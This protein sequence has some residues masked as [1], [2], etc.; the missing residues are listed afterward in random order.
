MNLNECE[1]KIINKIRSIFAD[2]QEK[3]FRDAYV[4]SQIN[5]ALAFQIRAMRKD[6]GLTQ[7]ELAKLTETKQSAISRMEN[8]DYGQFNLE[9]LKNLASAFDV[10][11]MVRFVPFSELA[12][13][14]AKLSPGDIN[15]QP[16]DKDHGLQDYSAFDGDNKVSTFS[17]RAGAFT[18]SRWNANYQPSVLVKTA[19][20]AIQN[21]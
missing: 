19:S 7:G 3:E 12:T 17:A 14:A 18:S 10:A 11:L 20:V 8:P 1:N 5:N 6:R 21:G 2:F 4:E 16:Y 13:R 9:T 15:I